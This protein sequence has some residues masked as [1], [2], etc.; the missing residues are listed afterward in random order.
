MSTQSIEAQNT[1]DSTLERAFAGELAPNR[2]IDQN[3]HT[4]DSLKQFF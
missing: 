4:N 1:V 3:K 2:Q